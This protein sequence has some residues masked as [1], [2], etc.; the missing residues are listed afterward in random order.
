MEL[1]NKRAVVTGGSAGIGQAIVLDL[2]KNGAEV[3]FTYVG[4]E[5]KEI[6]RQVESLGRKCLS[7]ESDVSILSEAEK[8]VAQVVEKLGGIEILINNAG[9]NWDEVVWKMTEEMWDKVLDTDLKGCFNY[10]RA[11]APIFKEQNSGKIVN[12]ASINGLRGKFGQANYAAAK[13]GIIGLT[14]TVAKELGKY[15][16]NVNAIA[17]GLIET[18]MIQK[19]PEEIKK[20]ALDETVFKRIGKPENVAHLVTFLCSEKAKHITGEVIKIDGGQYI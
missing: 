5:N 11:V 6:K 20:Q 13:A 4:P 14:K 2:A 19:L 17:P 16:V 7:L 12:I 9:I 10:I 15:N 18:E 3:A 8:T 1:K